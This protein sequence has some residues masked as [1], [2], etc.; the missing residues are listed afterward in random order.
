MHI[1]SDPFGV[2]TTLAT[3]E[4][5]VR[6]YR[7]HA[8]ADSLRIGLDRLP[9]TIRVLLENLLR[10]AAR[11]PFDA[12]DVHRLAF[13]PPGSPETT[14]FPFLPARVVL[15]DFTGVPAIVDLAAMRSAVVRL[16][17]DPARIN[18]RVPADLVIDHSVTVDAFGSDAAFG[19]N[20]ELEYER[21]RER[22]TLLRWAQQAFRHFRV[23]PPG[24]G[25]VHQVNLEY[26][27]RVIWTAQMGAETVAY[28]DT[29]VGT[30]SHTT[31]IS[32]LGVLGWGVEKA[33]DRSRA[34]KEGMPDVRR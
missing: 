31:M 7:L 12:D 5:T 14:E 33:A 29:L 20:I 30:D 32:G 22:Y 23:V 21:N 11:A 3:A 6:Y 2:R 24:T 19:R 17:G 16:G 8:L 9:F 15:Q 1:G 18:P 34:L 10:H 26:L 27:A 28:P 13:W 4:G 25:I